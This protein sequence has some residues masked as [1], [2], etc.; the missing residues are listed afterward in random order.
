MR[1]GDVP[2]HD[3]GLVD[4]VGGPCRQND[5]RR[6]PL[7][8]ARGAGPAS[9]STAYQSWGQG[10]LQLANNCE[11]TFLPDVKPVTVLEH[12]SRSERSGRLLLPSANW[13]RRPGGG[14]SASD[15]ARSGEKWRQMLRPRR[16]LLGAPA[17][18]PLKTLNCLTLDRLRCW[19]SGDS[20]AEHPQT[21]AE[22]GGRLSYPTALRRT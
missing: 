3:R 5:T 1:G 16:Y 4:R 20:Y 18:I 14:A 12:R 17:L 19:V 6:L 13:F 21:G 7:R 15:E 22:I 2:L 8:C 10:L 11:S 9:P